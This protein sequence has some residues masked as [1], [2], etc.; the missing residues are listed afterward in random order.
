[1]SLSVANILLQITGD[2]SS[3]Q[4]ELEDVARDLALFGRETAEATAELETGEAEAALDD[5]KFRLDEFSAKDVSADVNV[6]IAKAQSDLAALQAELKRID[7]EDVTVDIHTRKSLV[8]DIGSLVSQIDRLGQDTEGLNRG[9]LSTLASKLGSAWSEAEIFGVSLTRIATVGPAVVAVVVAI[10]GQLLAIVASAANAAAGVGAL[11][12]AFGATLIPGILLAIGAVA[13]FKAESGKAGTAAYALAGNLK[14]VWNAF[15]GATA[16]GSNA[17]FQGL[18]DAL[19]ELYPLVKSLRPAFTRLGEAGGDAF[20]L[21]GKQF[22]SPAW[23]KF[24]IFTTDSLAKLTPLF[25]R[26]F[27]AFAA[28]LRNIATVAMPFLIAGFRA[29]AK[30]LEAIAGKTS[31]IHG[32]RSEIGGMMESLGSWGHLLGGIVKLVGAFV[33]AFAPIGDK[34]VSALGDGAENLAKWLSSSE[35]LRKVKQFFEDTGP[36]AAEVG[37]FVLNLALAFI[38]LGQLVAPVLTPLVHLLNQVLQAANAALSYINDHSSGVA[39]ALALIL[40]PATVI[41]GAFGKLKGVAEDAFGV[42]KDVVSK[43]ASIVATPLEFIFGAPREVL[44]EVRD[45]W[46]TGKDIVGAVIDFL[47]HAPRDVL[48]VIRDVWQTAKGIIRD[49]IDFVLKAPRDVLGTIRDIWRDAKGVIT[50]VIDFV[51]KVPHDPAGAARELWGDVKGVITDA[52]AFVVRVPF[53]ALGQARELWGKIKDALSG[54]IDLVVQIV[55]DLSGLPSK[56]IGALGF[57]NGVEDLRDAMFAMVGER[58]PEL[59]FLPQGTDIYTA[60]ETRKILKSLARGIGQPPAAPAAASAPTRS[61]GG[62][63]YYDV[64]IQ[65][66]SSGYADPEIALSLL[67]TK[68]R[69]RGVLAA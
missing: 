56:V 68:L 59:A 45:I 14:D 19:R 23:R 60:D 5:L 35:G 48:G 67:D 54:A 12:V 18:S 43:A 9:P 32:L 44:A 63:N 21:L 22:S 50:D 26:S 62:D 38:Q 3:A 51:M 33:A 65:A 29:L 13:Q 66:P 1:M 16:G 4:R 47:L 6:K 52:I 69:A 57:A 49:A 24:F 53:D 61:G 20:R 46:K 27:G 8:S 39:S 42:V 31:D 17:V 28:I 64:T 58:G 40:T 15:K 11:A 25:A 36:L 7:G 34:I 30:G 37:K 10:I 2:S 55:P 41:V